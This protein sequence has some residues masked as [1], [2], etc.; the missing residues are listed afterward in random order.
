M[1]DR[2]HPRA[3]HIVDAARGLLEHHGPDALTMRRLADEVGIRAPSLYKHVPDKA[4]VEAALVADCLE[5]LAEALEAAE[6]RAAEVAATDRESSDGEAANGEATDADARDPLGILAAA[7]RA[8]AL[9][10]AHLYRLMTDRPLP[11]ELLPDG[12]EDRAAAPLARVTDDA[13]LARATWAFAHGMVLLELVGRFPHDA[14]LDATWRTGLR[15][16]G[17]RAHAL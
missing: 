8:Y 14:D 3:R 13:E 15:A 17:G 10:H 1:A 6:A 7:Y 11:R 5:E 12:L 4:A 9:A 16:L 2:L